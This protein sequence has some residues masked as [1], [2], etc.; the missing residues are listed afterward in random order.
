MFKLRVS[1]ERKGS[2]EEQKDVLRTFD[3]FVELHQK[4]SYTFGGG[5]LPRLASLF[6]CRH[7]HNDFMLKS[8]S[9]CDTWKITN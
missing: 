8:S 6:E 3:E 7:I 2:K 4:L 5:Q 1:R 9:F